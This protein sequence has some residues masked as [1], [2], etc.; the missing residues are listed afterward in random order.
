MDHFPGYHARKIKPAENY[1]VI[2]FAK[3]MNEDFGTKVKE[4]FDPE[5]EAALAAQ[6]TGQ[7]AISRDFLRQGLQSNRPQKLLRLCLI[8]NF[9]S[10]HS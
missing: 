10:V 5:T 1:D 7:F 8:A 9:C 3:A 2:S 4:L 6:K